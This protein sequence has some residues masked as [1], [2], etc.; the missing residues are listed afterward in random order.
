MF[1]R[2]VGCPKL[3]CQKNGTKKSRLA[4]EIAGL[5]FCPAGL[6]AIHCPQFLPSEVVSL[7]HPEFWSLC[8]SPVPPEVLT[9]LLEAP[10]S[11]SSPE[12]PLLESY[13]ESEFDLCCFWIYCTCFNCFF[14]FCFVPSNLLTRKDWG[15]VS[16]DRRSLPPLELSYLPRKSWGSTKQPANWR[17]GTTL[18]IYMCLGS[19]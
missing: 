6:I 16:I 4:E 9:F 17:S 8:L 14:A 15:L 1:C 13:S 11:T 2:E 12:L 5:W 18:P 7:Q 10:S 19:C 3:P